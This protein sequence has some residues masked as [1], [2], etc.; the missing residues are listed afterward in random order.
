[1]MIVNGLAAQ[2]G[3]RV[4]EGAFVVTHNQHG[5]DTEVPGTL[6]HLGQ[7]LRIVRLVHEEYINVLDG[8][9]AEGMSFIYEVEIVQFRLGILCRACFVLI[10]LLLPFHI[11][12]FNTVSIHFR[13][14]HRISSPHPSVKSAKIGSIRRCSGQA[15]FFKL[16]PVKCRC[17]GFRA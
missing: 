9:N 17:L 6:F 4:A 7:V 3:L 13:S 2:A 1:M 11:N 8:V 14:R 10:C 16:G 5:F 12:H 15:C